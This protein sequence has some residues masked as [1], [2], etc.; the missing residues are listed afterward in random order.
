MPTGK[1]IYDQAV[2]DAWQTRRAA[3]L[4]AHV[5][6]DAA[7]L[8][9]GGPTIVL[10]ALLTDHAWIYVAIGVILAVTVSR[11][12]MHARWMR[13]PHCARRILGATPSS[14]LPQPA[15]CRHC[16]HWLESPYASDE[17]AA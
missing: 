7:V 15:Y 13:C 10:S 12:V 6:L 16:L 1:V 11:S 8:L 14:R 4:R 9:L 5:R 17:P 3:Y 2:I